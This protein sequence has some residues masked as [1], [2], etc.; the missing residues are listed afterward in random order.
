MI[1]AVLK[2]IFLAEINKASKNPYKTIL[3]F[4]GRMGMS[5]QYLREKLLYQKSDTVLNEEAQ[6]EDQ[7]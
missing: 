3:V 7:Q 2:H 1:W 4:N 5:L 6:C